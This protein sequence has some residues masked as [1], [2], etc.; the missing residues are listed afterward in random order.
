MVTGND[1]YGYI[2]Q[3]IEYLRQLID[4]IVN[5]FKGL[6][7]DDPAPETPEA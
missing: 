1:D 7:A 2:A 3:F 5:L 6:Q 4:I